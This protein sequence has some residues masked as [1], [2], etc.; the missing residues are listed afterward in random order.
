MAYLLAY[1]CDRPLLIRWLPWQLYLPFRFLV[2]LLGLVPIG[3]LR[4]SLG[5]WSL[6]TCSKISSSV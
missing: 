1:F 5:L 2:F 3:Q 4:V 6:W